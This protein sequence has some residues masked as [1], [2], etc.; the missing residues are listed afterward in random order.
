MTQVRVPASFIRGGTS[1]GIFFRR[2]HLPERREAWDPLF[3]AALGSPD[4]YGRQMDGLGG[5]ISSLSKVVI[6][7]PS[8]RSDV[9]IEYTFGQVAVAEAHVDYGNNCGNLTSAVGPF[10][11]DEGIVEVAPGAEALVRLLN[12][13][14]QKRIDARFPLDGAE[15]AVEG[16]LELQGVAGSGAPVR[17]E[18]LDPGGAIT[19]RLL[20]TGQTSDVLDVPGLGEVTVSIVD[21][22]TA[23]AFVRAED[24]GLSGSELPDALEANPAALDRLQAIRAAAA[25][26]LGMTEDFEAERR[27]ARNRP[28]IAVVAP[29]LEARSLSGDRIAADDVDVTARAVSMGRPHRAFPLTAALCLAAA[30]RIEGT[31]VHSVA[32]QVA[33]PTADLRIGNPSGVMP[34]AAEV[35]HRS[36]HSAA[37]TIER[38]VAYR[39]VRRLMEGSILVPASRLAG[40]AR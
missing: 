2:E 17:L 13:N 26:R 11:V 15:A 32:R 21:A 25:V 20:P 9:D 4:P 28:F 27:A 33:D 5:G 35:R 22:T 18:F 6:V 34:L 29:P 19:G 38:A 16:D 3:L 36:A 8:S 14:T 1:K 10:A 7:E 23:V 31:V 40:G 30:A 12:L 39:T 37:W 24:V